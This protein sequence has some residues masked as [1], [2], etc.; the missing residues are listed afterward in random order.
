[1]TNWVETGFQTN[2][3]TETVIFSGGQSGVALLRHYRFLPIPRIPIQKRMGEVPISQMWIVRRLNRQQWYQQIIYNEVILAF[4]LKPVI[5]IIPEGYLV[6][7]LD[8]CFWQE[9]EYEPHWSLSMILFLSI[10]AA[11]HGIQDGEINKAGENLQRG[12]RLL[13]LVSE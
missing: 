2:Q 7:C 3:P 13:I 6:Y 10:F 9:Q 8:C 1:M 12:S 5:N 4:L 11:F